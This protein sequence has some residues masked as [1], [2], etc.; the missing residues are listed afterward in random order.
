MPVPPE[1]LV[2]ILAL[3]ALWAA[4]D[5]AADARNALAGADAALTEALLRI[6]V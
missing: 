3:L 6:P 4:Q 5:A 2:A 1:P